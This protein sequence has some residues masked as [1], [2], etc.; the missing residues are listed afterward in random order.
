MYL[1][2]P[3]Q[4]EMMELYFL[5]LCFVWIDLGKYSAKRPYM[6]TNTVMQKSTQMSSG[7]YNTFETL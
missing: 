2:K 7:M 4:Q 1:H 5:L 6:H 3:P